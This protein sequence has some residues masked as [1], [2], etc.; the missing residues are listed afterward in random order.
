MEVL[1]K[2]TDAVDITLNVGPAVQGQALDGPIESKA[3]TFLKEFLVYLK[4]AFTFIS[5]S[6]STT[7]L[8]RQHYNG[9]C[10]SNRI[11]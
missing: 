5:H 1:P 8:I 6:R 11:I 7:N 9:A 4:G 3:M 2:P 10:S